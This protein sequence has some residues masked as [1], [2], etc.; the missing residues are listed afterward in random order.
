[1]GG[2][3]VKTAWPIRDRQLT[4][5]QIRELQAKLKKM[6]YD[7]GEIDGRAGEMLRTAVCAYQEKN[8]RTPDGYPTLDLLE[9]IR[10]RE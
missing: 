2:P 5:A 10:R 1:M 7:V 6:G 4:P 9:N 8:G 3:G